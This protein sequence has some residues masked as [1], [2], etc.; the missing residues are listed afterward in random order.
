MNFGRVDR[1]NIRLFR[2]SH[3]VKETITHITVAIIMTVKLVFGN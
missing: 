2:H 3:K 1:R